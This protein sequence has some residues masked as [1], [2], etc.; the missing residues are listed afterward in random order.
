MNGGNVTSIENVSLDRTSPSAGLSVAKLRCADFAAAYI[1][2]LR[3]TQE[4]FVRR[5]IEVMRYRLQGLQR[6]SG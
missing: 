5:A 3:F 6:L 4:N 2:Y 1:V